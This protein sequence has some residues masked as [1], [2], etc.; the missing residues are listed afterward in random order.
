MGLRFSENCLK[1]IIQMG[2]AV[3][4]FHKCRG[5]ESTEGTVQFIEAD[6]HKLYIN[7]K[8]NQMLSAHKEKMCL[9]LQL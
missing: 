8:P 9:T 6:K 3:F 1:D 2:F 7:I 5:Q 4:F